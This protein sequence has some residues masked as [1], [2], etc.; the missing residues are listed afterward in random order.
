MPHGPK[1]AVDGGQVVALAVLW[2]VVLLGMGAVAIDVGS[3]YLA[4]RQV[5]ASVDAA[6]LAGAGQLPAGWSTAQ[7]AAAATFAT[8]GKPGDTAITENT[9]TLA[10]NDTVKVSGV[11]FSPSYF[12]N[13]FGIDSATIRA[14]ASATV[15]S[16]SK[17]SSTGQVMPWAIMRAS[18]ALG[19][20]YSIYTD[21]TSSNNGALSLPLNDS[22]GNC[23]TSTT[24]GDDYRQSITGPGAGGSAVCDVSVGEILS[25]KSGQN[26]GPTKQGIDSRI[27]SWDPLSAIVQITGNG[28]AVILKPNSPQLVILPVVESLSGGTT[29]PGG[30]GQVRVVGFACFVLTQPG[31]ADGGKSVLGTFVGLQLT[32]TGWT[33]GGFDP[34]KNTAYTIEL[35]K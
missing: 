30:A 33:T 7:T 3:W 28:N 34:T 8:N 2:M 5:Q 32:D 16:Y 14:T 29:W 31:Y 35:T 27:A 12:A 4:K 19:S 9:T 15:K 18:W 26:T 21:N 25:V 6:A 20:Q 1:R 13:V 10:S 23:D 22:S 24:G 17:I 11:R